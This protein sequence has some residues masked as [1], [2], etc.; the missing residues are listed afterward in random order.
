M[1]R[2]PGMA[3]GLHLACNLQSLALTPLPKH[4]LEHLV[5]GDDGNNQVL[6]ILKCRLEVGRLPGVCEILKPSG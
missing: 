5:N 6:G 1:C 4:L 3:G 2:G